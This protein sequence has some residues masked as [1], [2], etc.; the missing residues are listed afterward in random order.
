[1]KYMQFAKA[2]G[3]AGFYAAMPKGQE[4][5]A[6]EQ[7]AE[8]EKTAAVAPGLMEKSKAKGRAG[9]HSASKGK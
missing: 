6:E 9:F 7:K 2:K 4:K 3:Q 8:A 1:M 5:K